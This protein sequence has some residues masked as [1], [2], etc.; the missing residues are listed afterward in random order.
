[1]NTNN[2][3]LQ[4][5]NDLDDSILNAIGRGAMS[6][7]YS[8]ADGDDFD[9][10]ADYGDEDSFEDEGEVTEVGGLEGEEEAAK[11][12]ALVREEKRKFK[13]KYGKA[14]I[15]TKWVKSCK[16][17]I[18]PKVP[19]IVRTKGWRF[20]WKNWKKSGG[21]AKLKQFAKGE[22]AERPNPTQ[23]PV[24]PPAPPVNPSGTKP[25]DASSPTNTT[26]TGVEDKTKTQENA[27]QDT[28]GD[29]GDDNI[30]GMPK[31]LAIGIGVL[32]LVVGGFIAYKKISKK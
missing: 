13:A 22:I 32:I 12:R 17:R 2:L 27:G 21:L 28:G 8:S 9:D 18:C 3:D 11:F 24:K 16:A 15:S 10:S 29:L 30:L 7:A 31:P 25:G 6:G 19:K 5:Y 26:R 20:H 23:P 1:M 14:K 4:L